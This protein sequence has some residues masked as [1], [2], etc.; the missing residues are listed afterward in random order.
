MKTVRMLSIILHLFVG[1]GAMAGGLACLLDPYAPLGA[2]VTMLEGSPFDSFLIPGIILFGL[3]GIG[4]VLGGIL[5]RLHWKYQPYVSGLLG[6]ALVVW[7]IVQC[8]ILRDVVFLHVLF[9][10]FGAVQGCLA[11]AMLFHQKLF[12][13]NIV[14]RL[15]DNLRTKH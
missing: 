11:L 1:V 15:W 10:G 3:I 8:I 4:N 13:A 5:F 9:F 12:P 7:I 2:P 6:G 14:L